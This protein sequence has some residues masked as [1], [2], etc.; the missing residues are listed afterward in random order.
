MGLL[1]FRRKKSEET[2]DLNQLLMKA[3]SGNE[4]ARNQLLREYIPFVAKSASQATGR[5]IRRGQDDEFS[6]AL[7][8]FNEA[9]ER[10]DLNRGTSFLGFADT[11][12][13]RRLIDYYRSKQSKQRDLPF[14]EFEVEDEEENVINYVEVQKSVEE[15]QKQV[16][17]DARRHEILHFT[18]LLMQFDISMEELVDLSPKH[19]DA[20]ENAMEVAKVIASQQEF[21]DYLMAKK[22]LPLKA[23]MKHV[24]VSRKTIERQRKYIIAV[25]LI[26]IGD[27][28]MLQDYII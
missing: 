3:R 6:I 24:S 21:C 22:S 18:E 27:F 16:E 7:S 11:V 9:I 17:S 1:P 2:S 8:A 20:R 12:I 19:Q 4:E 23:L 28:E 15:H 26:L 13:K 10:Y 14:S 25:S 5:Y